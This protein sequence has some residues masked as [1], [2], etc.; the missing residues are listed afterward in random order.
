M[1]G[2][3]G[4]SGNAARRGQLIQCQSERETRH[5]PELISGVDSPWQCKADVDLLQFH[6]VTDEAGREA[7]THLGPD[8]QRRQTDHDTG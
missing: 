6:A 8:L 1:P 7:K 4:I 3:P 2:L 5:P